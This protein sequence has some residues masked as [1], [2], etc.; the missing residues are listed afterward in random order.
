MGANRK[1]KRADLAHSAVNCWCDQSP[2]AQSGVPG[3]EQ[4]RALDLEWAE[5]QSAD[6]GG[7]GRAQSKP[8]PS[9]SSRRHAC[10][11]EREGHRS[12]AD[13][14]DLHRSAS[15]LVT[16]FV[17]SCEA[18]FRSPSTRNR[19]PLRCTRW[20]RITQATGLPVPKTI[21]RSSETS[22]VRLRPC[23]YSGWSRRR[24]RYPAR[25]APRRNPSRGM[26]R[27]RSCDGCWIKSWSSAFRSSC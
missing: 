15:D 9:R 27:S 6:G 13:H 5:L 2:H 16:E 12:A 11:E 23:S 8:G 17:R 26:R 14:E 10:S 25:I 3:G 1:T 20:G 18:C 24:A 7:I 19:K 21:A 4:T 22:A